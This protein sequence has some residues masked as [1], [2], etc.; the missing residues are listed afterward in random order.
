MKFSPDSAKN[1]LKNTMLGI[2]A[3][4]LSIGALHA[5]EKPASNK[6]DQGK[7]ELTVSPVDVRILQKI[8][9]LEKQLKH[10]G[11]KEIHDGKKAYVF[12]TESELSNNTDYDVVNTKLENIF[13]EDFE[14]DFINNES[15]DY[16]V[17]DRNINNLEA[18]GE[19]YEI[20]QRND[21]K[22]IVLS[23]YIA[24]TDYVIF[25]LEPRDLS[26]EYK[27]TFTIVDMKTKQLKKHTFT[28]SSEETFKK[29]QEIRAHYK[30][31]GFDDNSIKSIQDVKLNN[32]DEISKQ[33][34]EELHK[35]I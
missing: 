21:S 7:Q 22:D 29:A 17:L 30:E 35:I 10:P 26:Y 19:E 8:D 3:T 16:H 11:S 1:A 33:I 34:T 28:I 4:V 14:S 32:F 5:K 23:K 2:T 15:R 12:I 20:D 24:P 13:K 9:A 27:G 31:K 18:L 25:K 6:D